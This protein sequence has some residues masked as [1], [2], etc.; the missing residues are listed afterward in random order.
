MRPRNGNGK[1]R[2]FKVLQI[3][4]VKSIANKVE[5]QASLGEEIMTEI[6]L[7]S[8]RQKEHLQINKKTKKAKTLDN[9]QKDDHPL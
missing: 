8:I 2:Q 1:D 3:F 6:H 4:I 5:R 7:L 9:I